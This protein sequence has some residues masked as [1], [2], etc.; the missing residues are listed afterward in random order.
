MGRKTQIFVIFTVLT[1]ITSLFSYARPDT[2]HFR[3]RYK[4][5]RTEIDSTFTDNTEKIQDMRDFLGKVRED[6]LITVTG[7]QFRGTASPEGPYEWNQY[8]SENRLR[9]FK[10][11]VREY[12]D[13]P[14]S[15][16]ISSAADIPW[17]EFR[18]RV[19]ESEIL[20][21][22]EIL[23]VIDQGPALVPF[24]GG[25][26]IDHRLLKLKKMHG[27][28][29][30]TS[31]LDILFDL[32]YGDAIF[33]YSRRMPF[34]LT[35]ELMLFDFAVEKPEPNLTLSPLR[36][37]TWTPRLYLKTN[38]AAWIL[39]SANVAFEAD[40]T[41][42]WSVT[43]PVYYCA[44]DWI[45]STIKF[46]NLSIMPEFRYWFNSHAND[47]FFLGAHFK[48]AYFN[49]AFDGEKRFQDYRGRTPA[50]GGGVSAGYRLPISANGR[51]RMEFA[52]GAGA[53]KLDY[54]EFRN[55]PDVKDGEWLA[56]KHG[57]YIG[58]DDVQITFAYTFD[59]T[60]YTRYYFQKGGRK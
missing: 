28:M 10:A 19:D 9:N 49:F 57:T 33:S 26:H 29:V 50:L 16:I 56:R 12:I 60:K 22:D 30:W 54:S 5:N 15:I 17:D 8:L 25:R 55:T 48:V 43:L 53:Y 7:I 13:I 59:L 52:V 36:V 2:A 14:D 11:L 51:W 40:L 24:W 3:L 6:S 4:L 37:T 1:A 20:Y 23:E 32:R 58:L 27:G 18:D 42:H 21:K 35:P 44:M 41:R 45:K 39:F 38:V 34:S 47:G 31:L 46:R